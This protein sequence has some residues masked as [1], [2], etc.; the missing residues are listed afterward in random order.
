MFDIS[1]SYYM[2]YAIATF[3]V[4]VWV[5]YDT[6]YQLDTSHTTHE[7]IVHIFFV[8]YTFV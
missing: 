5:A 7:S 2:G 6:I 1:F 3:K 4:F 8:R